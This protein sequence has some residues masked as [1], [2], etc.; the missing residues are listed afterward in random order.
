MPSGYVRDCVPDNIF[1]VVVGDRPYAEQQFAAE[2]PE[3]RG[4]Y[5]SI[6]PRIY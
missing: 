5:F 1:V 6:L 4:T 3:F 2:V